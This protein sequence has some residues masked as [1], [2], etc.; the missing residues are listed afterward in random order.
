M[1]VLILMLF[2]VANVAMASIGKIT[3]FK[4]SVNISRDSQDIRAELNLDVE[5]NDT[6][7]TKKNSNAI[8]K[9]NDKTIITVGK[10]STLVIEEYLFDETN[11]SNSKTQFNFLKGTFKSVTGTIGHINPDKFRLKTR[12][13]NIGIRGTV[14]L[15]NQKLIACT[16]GSI[17]VKSKSKSVILN[18]GEYVDIKDDKELTSPKKLS[19]EI[20]AMLM[21]E[22]G[23]PS[24]YDSEG[25]DGGVS[26]LK[27]ATQAVSTSSQANSTAT[28]SS[29]GDGGNSGDGGAGGGGGGSG[30]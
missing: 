9:F 10:D 28:G 11:K 8:I 1:K 15:G 7:S 21:N 6:I 14:T 16:K 19:D 23:V 22:L 17:S 24:Q 5:R 20:L 12:T 30:H 13:A 29:S 3:S 25:G 18:A 2:I 27:A 26:G 4:G